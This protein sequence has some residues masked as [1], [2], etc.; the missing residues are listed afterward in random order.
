M[1]APVHR[2]AQARLRPMQIDEQS[3]QPP[4]FSV[5]MQQLA[6]AELPDHLMVAMQR[7]RPHSAAARRFPFHAPDGRSSPAPPSASKPH[8][9][10]LE[11]APADRAPGAQAIVL[12]RHTLGGA[13]TAQ[14]FQDLATQLIAHTTRRLRNMRRPHGPRTRWA[15][16]TTARACV[17]EAPLRPNPVT[18]DEMDARLGRALLTSCLPPS[19]PTSTPNPFTMR[20]KAM[21][22]ILAVDAT[23]WLRQMVPFD[24]DE[25]LLRRRRIRRWSGRLREGQLPRLRPGADRP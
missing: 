2:I 9:G 10:Q 24:S 12:A 20:E 11:T 14:Q 23:G 22:S 18:Q 21:H 7:P 13:I 3:P 16:T 5:G 4:P 17:E 8:H 6:A 19:C 15:T 25:R 1:I